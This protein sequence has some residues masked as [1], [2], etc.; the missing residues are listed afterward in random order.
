[1]NN[2]LVYDVNDRPPFGKMLIFAFQ[3][4]LAIMAA[5]IA[6]P[7]IIGLPTQIPAAILGAGLGTIVYLL[8]TKFKS[9]VIISSSFAFLS[10]LST[11]I[12][13]GYCGIILGGILAGLVYVVLALIIKFVGSKWVSKLMPPVIIGPTVA[14]IGLS[15]AGSAMGDI[16][17]ASGATINASYNLVALFCG[18]VTLITICICST[19]KKFKM[20]RLIPFII[21]IGMGYA[22]ASIFSIFGYCFNV[23][24]LKIV[25]WKPLV[26]NFVKDGSFTGVTALLNYPDF[27]LI[28]AIKELANGKIVSEAI[29]A[30]N[31]NATMITW[32]GVGEIILAFVPVALVVFAEHIADHKNL[33]SIIGHDLVEGEPGLCRT[34]LGDGVGSMVGT[35]FG[36]CPNTTYGESVG[37]VAITKNASVSTIFT[38]AVMCIILSFISPIMALLQT[39]PSC[40][41]GGVCLTLYGFIAVSGLKMFKDIDLGDNKNLFTVSTILIAGIGGL[42]IKIPYALQNDGTVSKTITITSIATA[43]IL[44]IVVHAIIQ[45]IEKKQ[46]DDE[47]SDEPESLIAGAVAPKANFEVG[48]NEIAIEEQKEREEAVVEEFR[49]EEA[50]EAQEDGETANTEE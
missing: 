4:V 18:L 46:G 20:G 49:K 33:G 7:T 22:V 37:C 6:V 41:M 43:L 44:G 3:Q 47:Q 1:M 30:A 29:L 48:V 9:P 32:A 19:Q 38:A 27:A 31:G 14:L 24:Y 26:D 11:A 21:G 10:S 15:L 42:S 36:I 16:V 40:V 28:E 50:Q 23:E 39:I 8:F 12:A 5:T 2:Q 17:K 45:A 25:N 13:F 35:V 34:L